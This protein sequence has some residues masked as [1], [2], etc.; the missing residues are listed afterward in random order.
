MVYRHVNKSVFKSL[1]QEGISYTDDFYEGQFSLAESGR[2]HL[3][4]QE[5]KSTKLPLASSPECIFQRNYKQ[6]DF[7]SP[8]LP[9]SPP[10]PT[11]CSN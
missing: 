6:P 1:I 5:R 7:S 8:S 2:I 9:S 11:H 10:P 4:I 3:G